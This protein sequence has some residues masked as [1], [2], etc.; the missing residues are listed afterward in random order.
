MELAQLQEFWQ[1]SLGVD[2]LET[3]SPLKTLSLG[4]EGPAAPGAVALFPPGKGFVPLEPLGSGGMGVVVRARQNCLGREVALK[5]LHPERNEGARG[6]RAR[7]NFLAE[8][9]I[10]GRLEHPN[11]V[12]VHELG[13][14][15][16]GE[17][18][19]A[20]KLVEGRSWRALLDERSAGAD[21][22]L[23]L[24]VLLQVCNA[25]AF[26][27][28]RKVVHNDLKPDN[29]M[30]GPFG[31]V[32]VMDWGLAVSFG[33]PE[34]DS[35][36]RHASDIRDVCGT[37]CYMA[38]EQAR[39]EGAA[40]GPPTDVFLLGGILYE[41]L[42]GA[43][44]RTPRNVIH[45]L[46]A[47]AT[48]EQP[49]FDPDLPRELRSTCE[50][51]LQ[52]EIEQ[53]H[54]TVQAF[55][56]ELRDYLRHRESLS[57]S[58][59]AGQTL[60]SCRERSRRLASLEE[61]ARNRLYEDFAASL[62]GFEQALRLWDQNPEAQT[63]RT[64]A[65]L[66]FAETAI[67]QGDLRLAGAQ[68]AYLG[69]EDAGAARTQ[70][71]RLATA[72]TLQRRQRTTRRLLAGA[73]LLAL[74]CLFV[75]LELSRRWIAEESRQ[76]R[77]DRDLALGVV[78]A[79]SR[80]V[81]RLRQGFRSQEAYALARELSRSAL[82]HWERLEDR[83]AP[84]EFL[85]RTARIRIEA[86]QLDL[87][88][89]QGVATARAELQALLEE[90]QPLLDAEPELRLLAAR[91]VRLLAGIDFEAGAFSAAASGL[92]RSL[93]LLQPLDGEEAGVRHQRRMSLQLAGRVWEACGDED[94]ARASL[95][96]AHT[97]DRA[98]LAAGEAASRDYL[99]GSHLEL[100]ELLD[101]QGA[102]QEAEEHLR[103][104]VALARELVD[105]AALS[106]GRRQLLA[107]SL[108]RL[109]HFLWHRGRG[110]EAG[111]RLREAARLAAELWERNLSLPD[112]MRVLVGIFC[113]YVE[114]LLERGDLRAAEDE[115]QGALEVARQLV[116]LSQ[117]AL[118][119]DALAR[120]LVARAKVLEQR[121]DFARS[122]SLCAEAVRLRSAIV[123]E[124][125]E[126]H[127][128]VIALA[129]DQALLSALRGERGQVAEALAAAEAS[130][131]C[132]AGLDEVPSRS[133][134]ARVSRVVGLLARGR[135]YLLA[136]DS[137]AAEAD[138]QAA[139]ELSTE[140]LQ[141]GPQRTQDIYR[142]AVA[143]GDVARVLWR[144]D[145]REAA[146][147]VFHEL[148]PH[149]DRL[150]D[151]DPSNLLVQGTRLRMQLIYA[152]AL[153]LDAP[154]EAGRV[155]DHCLEVAAGFSHSTPAVDAERARVHYARG[156]LAGLNGEQTRVEAELG[157]ALALQQRLYAEDSSDF[158]RQHELALSHCALGRFRR[159]AGELPGAGTALERGSALLSGLLEQHPGH[160]RLGQDLVLAWLEL[161]Q[162]ALERGQLAAAGV[163]LRE[164]FVLQ[165][166]LAAR[167]IPGQ[168]LE[169]TTRSA[170]FDLL[171]GLVE[172]G[173]ELR[174]AGDAEAALPLLAEAER[175]ARLLFEEAPEAE[176]T[177]KNLFL[178]LY[179]LGLACLAAGELDEAERT[180]HEADALRPNYLV[181]LRLAELQ[182]LRGAWVAA[183]AQFSEAIR[184]D[185]EQG[186]SYL[187]RG[188]VRLLSGD[189]GGARSDFAAAAARGEPA[190]G[191]LWAGDEPS[192]QDLASGDD[193]IAA[194]AAAALGQHS[195]A[196]LLEAA[197]DDLGKLCE[198]WAF[199]GFWAEQDGRQETAREHYQR[200][201][202]T[203]AYGYSEYR[204]ARD[205][206]RRWH[207]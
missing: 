165:R 163:P 150:A 101:D 93:Q 52:P 49:R 47:I 202:Q 128:L 27:H 64:E 138:V 32:Q 23:Q 95:I 133:T 78:D 36:T 120:A 200:C 113:D 30:L 197:A 40:I 29:V 185:P 69:E 68:L 147:A 10:H 118:D 26:A 89:G 105:E 51:A 123:A 46:A 109:G 193:W 206:L 181:A 76:A 136:G 18:Y 84:G 149:L 182:R 81:E 116:D 99:C 22:E 28:S 162:W 82:A 199:L 112:S 73:L 132:L 178:S 140:L 92:E 2:C 110:E 171:E 58:R 14:N 131:Q 33:P 54:P 65:R 77:I 170:L 53:R 83:L 71:R 158:H 151:T 115:S 126:R 201:L 15:E 141:S 111:P 161:G 35:P 24:E 160:V 39:G 195:Q 44:P 61:A 119:R 9:H 129:N 11:I 154:E 5:T 108:A 207:E 56:T 103:A 12:P 169:V 176:H 34:P 13:V 155:L 186:I 117:S 21:L 59:G 124:Q 4:A 134:R 45:V 205:R 20:M 180:L 127:Q 8:A 177:S 7:R 63:G 139:R 87:E 188:H 122:D 174:Q 80:D 42:H 85:A 96:E 191:A 184:R 204:W 172:S 75:G 70:Q 17:L 31:E 167:N 38:P 90:L 173:G 156:V 91:A 190:Y 55:Q 164:A 121:D 198:A 145:A 114:F 57:I 157:A 143:L 62:A 106:A 107:R 168:R 179:S 125:P 25:V 100:G 74:V 152:Q 148:L 196:Q 88:R 142:L 104:A 37:P 72:Q 41:I 183:V 203:E 146:R 43:P 66:Q 153:M 16:Q 19:L 60:A 1:T 6:S 97:L 50:R 67:S 187:L 94:Q 130:L 137:R 102:Q 166:A 135:A 48:G 194:L 79:L 144:E 175:A 86:V 3:L 98:L 192:L 159:L 189:E